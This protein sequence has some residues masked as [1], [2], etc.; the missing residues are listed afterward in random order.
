MVIGLHPDESVPLIKRAARSMQSAEE[1]F[2]PRNKPVH[3]IESLRDFCDVAFFDVTTNYIQPRY[4]E[5]LNTPTPVL[6]R[7]FKED[8]KNILVGMIDSSERLKVRM[9]DFRINGIVFPDKN[10][11][12][13]WEMG[14]VIRE[15]DFFGLNRDLL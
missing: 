11:K 9:N 13:P 1:N 3:I 10:G 2:D 4:V 14:F 12:W 6:K 8:A 15:I 5:L 7:Y